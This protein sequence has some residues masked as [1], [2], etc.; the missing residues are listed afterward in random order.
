MLTPPFA[1]VSDLTARWRPL[2]TDEQTRATTLLLD[3]SQMI[4][5]EDTRGILSAL[6]VATATHMRIACKMV[7]RAMG[8]PTDAPPV[9][10]F[11]QTMGPFT[12]AGTLAGASGDLY[13]TKAERRQLGFTRQRASN[14]AMWAEPVA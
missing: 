5:D 4:L 8:T 3:A 6:T 12:N 14:V 1:A 9:T 10:Q 11:S 2:S 7:E 13:L